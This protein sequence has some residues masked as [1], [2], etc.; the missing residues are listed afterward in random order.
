MTADE[1]RC[2]ALRLP[3]TQEQ[4]HQGH[5]DFRVGGKVFATLGPD[6]DW[7]MVK[8]TPDQQAFVT[9]RDPTAFQPFSGAWGGQGCTRI[10]LSI[11]ETS[12][13]RQAL[14][15]AW[16]NTAPAS[17]NQQFDDESL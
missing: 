1:F 15:A 2:L 9:R 11:A 17:L 16:R 8:L 10:E 6:E 4:A 14:I 5:P 3:A 12:A 13:A 7:A